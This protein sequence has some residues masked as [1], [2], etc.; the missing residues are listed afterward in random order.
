VA[1]KMRKRMELI[2]KVTLNH[3]AFRY[4]EPPPPRLCSIGQYLAEYRNEVKGFATLGA[5]AL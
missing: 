4:T 5:L 2:D 1:V 3:G